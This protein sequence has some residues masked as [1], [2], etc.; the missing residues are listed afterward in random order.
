[1]RHLLEVLVVVTVISGGFLLV[2]VVRTQIFECESHRNIFPSD[3]SKQ[4]VSSRGNVSS[5]NIQNE[6]NEF[7]CKCRICFW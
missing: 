1:M 4:N 3:Y 5:S 2:W 6:A 7:S